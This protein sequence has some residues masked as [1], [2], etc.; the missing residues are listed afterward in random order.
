MPLVTRDRYPEVHRTGFASLPAFLG[1]LSMKHSDLVANAILLRPA[2][3]FD[4]ELGHT[5]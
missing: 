4:A 1:R 2:S 5:K 3:A